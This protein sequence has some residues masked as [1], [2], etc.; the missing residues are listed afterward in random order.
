MGIHHPPYADT[1]RSRRVR[2]YRFAEP[3]GVPVVGTG[4]VEVNRVRWMTQR[5]RKG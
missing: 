1:D 3:G 2:E 5:G 4:G